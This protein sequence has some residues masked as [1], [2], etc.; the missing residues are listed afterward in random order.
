MPHLC[1]VFA[2]AGTNDEHEEATA[3]TTADES[4]TASNSRSSKRK[5]AEEESFEPTGDND[6]DSGLSDGESEVS[7]PHKR[8]K[9]GNRDS[10]EPSPLKGKSKS[11]GKKKA[12]ESSP[13]PAEVRTT[14][15]ASQA[16]KEDPYEAEGFEPTTFD[17]RAAKEGLGILPKSFRASLLKGTSVL[18]L[19]GCGNCMVRNR[20]CRRENGHARCDA[21]VKSG[22]SRCSDSFSI[23][24][25]LQVINYLEPLTVFSDQS[26]NSAFNELRDA[27]YSQVLCDRQV[28]LAN[29]R[30]LRARA[31]LRALMNGSEVAF[32]G[33]VI[34]G[35]DS[36]AE[37]EVE[38]YTKLFKTARAD[39]EREF[40]MP[41]GTRADEYYDEYDS[42]YEGS[43]GSA[44]DEEEGE[45]VRVIAVE[46]AEVA[47][48]PSPMQE[49]APVTREPAATTISL[50]DA[51]A[52]DEA[53]RDEFVEGSSRGGT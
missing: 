42:Q 52:A 38:F 11:K 6:Q 35:I 31:N 10:E 43:Q 46:D 48:E 34:P 40:Y 15:G 17:I 41:D 45:E 39:S 53:G 51:I 7:P 9:K 37:E 50:D 44:M 24:E 18:R 32:K 16:H 23:P 25:Y 12:D 47:R 4:D 33:K 49:D 20:K 26:W 19:L 28:T 22:M 21:C 1:L 27:H 29:A 3:G 2:E 8:S 30:L 5:R 36:V 13:G 14:R